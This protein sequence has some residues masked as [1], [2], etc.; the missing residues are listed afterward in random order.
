MLKKLRLKF[1]LINMT[2][3]VVMLGIIF[4]LVI[5]YTAR[6][7]ESESLQMMQAI[8]SG[9]ISLPRPGQ[10]QKEVRLPYFTLE[11]T[12]QGKILTAG[13]DDF[14]LTDEAFLQ[15]LIQMSYAVDAESG[16]LAEYD[17]RFW[18]STAPGPQRLVFVDMTSERATLA[19]LIRTCLVIGAVSVLLFFGI[20]MLLARWAVRPVAE[21]WELQRQFIADASHELKTPLT[22]I[23]TN[24]E[25]LQDPGLDEAQSSRFSASILTMSRQMR[26]LVESLLELA[27]VDSGTVRVALNTVDLSALVSDGILPFEPLFF[28]RGMTLECTV[29]P[30]LSLRG[31][32]SHLRQVLEILL[33][34]AMKYGLPGG[35]VWVEL[36]KQGNHAIL[37]VANRGEPIP[38]EELKTIFKRFYRRDKARSMTGSY[39]LGL[40]IAQRIVESHRGRIWAESRS[41]V[42]AFFVQLPM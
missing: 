13:S 38:P 7:L 18:R 6:S 22:V 28:E 1:I 20:S 32:E 34:N 33:D 8:G 29:A 2:L 24:A 31:S 39:G 27:R 10:Q 9:P 41:G 25:M 12:T 35:Q 37:A 16:V 4:A 26:G 5:Q 3:V 15:E 36:K 11:I 42:N 21:A 40:S 17:L 23:L 19:N 30:G 14:D